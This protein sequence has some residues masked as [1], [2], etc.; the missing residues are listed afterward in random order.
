MPFDIIYVKLTN[1]QSRINQSRLLSK[2][3]WIEKTKINIGVSDT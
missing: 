2:R 3:S 1:Q